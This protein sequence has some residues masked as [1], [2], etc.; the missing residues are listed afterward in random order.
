MNAPA[1][2]KVWEDDAEEP[3]P[4]PLP[5]KPTAPPTG[6]V[7]A[8]GPGSGDDAEEPAPLSHPTIRLRINGTWEDVKIADLNR[9]KATADEPTP[10]FDR[11]LFSSDG[12]VVLD[13][14][15]LLMMTDVEVL[16]VTKFAARVASDVAVEAEAAGKSYGSVVDAILATAPPGPTDH[17]IK[18][19]KE[20]ALRYAALADPDN[21]EAPVVRVIKWLR[22]NGITGVTVSA[23]TK[24]ARTLAGVRRRKRTLPAE[25][26][27]GHR[28]PELIRKVFP[29]APVPEEHQIP[30]RWEVGGYAITP[31]ADGGLKVRREAGQK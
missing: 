14:G 15:D 9:G 28:H 1:N 22:S 4:P 26:F 7:A 8:N 6:T 3:E 30:L 19:V 5:T 13:L 25:E 17:Q 10:V 12:K 11:S 24:Q 16:D 21:M 29:D 2:N 18:R 31:A 20:A 23:L 27:M